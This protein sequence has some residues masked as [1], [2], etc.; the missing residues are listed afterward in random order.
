MQKCISFWSMSMWSREL[1]VGVD[2]YLSS[3]KIYISNACV[4]FERFDDAKLPMKLFLMS[5]CLRAYND[6]PGSD[7]MWGLRY[8][9]TL[10]SRFNAASA[11]VGLTFFICM[12]DN[13]SIA[14]ETLLMRTLPLNEAGTKE[15][16]NAPYFNLLMISSMVSIFGFTMT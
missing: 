7:W 2:G 10:S 9:Y 13:G 14:T 5:P 6:I 4:Y 11:I 3:G 1:M 8:S 12:M 15:T 16:Y